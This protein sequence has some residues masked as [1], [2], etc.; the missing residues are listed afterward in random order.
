MLKPYCPK[1]IEVAWTQNNLG[2]T[3]EDEAQFLNVLPAQIFFPIRKTINA[4]DL[5][6]NKCFL[7]NIK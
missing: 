4:F 2:S 3:K 5:H 6:C 1:G 7:I